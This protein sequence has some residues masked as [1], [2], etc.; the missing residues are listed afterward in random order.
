MI[1]R[2]KYVAL[3]VFLLVSTGLISCGIKEN[4]FLPQV[5]ESDIR[6]ESNT[7]A[8]ITLP[9]IPFDYSYANSYSIFYRIYKSD[10][11]ILSISTDQDR[12]LINPSL[13]SDYSYFNTYADPVNETA[14]IT[15]R[16]FSNRNYHE[17]EFV[18][19]GNSEILPKAGGTLTITFT[20]GMTQG[21][22]AAVISG[23]ATTHNLCRSRDLFSPKEDKLFA[24]NDFDVPG[25]TNSN[26][27]DLTGDTASPYAFVSMYIVAKGTDITDF[28]SIYSKPTHINIFKLYW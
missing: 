25:N 15:S 4:F 18:G 12:Y 14:F 16:E 19:A 5:P 27:A 10:N 20:T 24:L 3:A 23:L 7:R 21:Y 8:V 9:A 22:P 11:D 13:S 26:N 17:L 2:G 6:R 28:T 1:K